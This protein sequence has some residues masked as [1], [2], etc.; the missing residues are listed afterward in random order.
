[1]YKVCKA[2]F[3]CSILFIC[4]YI[5]PPLPV[6]SFTEMKVLIGSNATLSCEAA[7]EP[8]HRFQWKFNFSDIATNETK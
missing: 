3:Q 7:S 8:L 5:A 4:Y 1:M 6:A 2:F